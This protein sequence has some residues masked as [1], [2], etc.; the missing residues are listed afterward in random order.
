MYSLNRDYDKSPYVFYDQIYKDFKI[1]KCDVKIR[2]LAIGC[3]NLENEEI[4]YKLSR[5]ESCIMIK[6]EQ[7]KSKMEAELNCLGLP[8]PSVDYKDPPLTLLTQNPY[9][10]GGFLS[11]S[12]KSVNFTPLCEKATSIFSYQ[13]NGYDI[14]R[15]INFKRKALK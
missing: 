7:N 2:V 6:T 8:M 10:W 11:S 1:K 14:G 13:I 9:M 15:V 4:K 5:P 3:L 12:L